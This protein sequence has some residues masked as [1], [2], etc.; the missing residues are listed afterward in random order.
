[1]PRD[2]SGNFTRPVAP[3]TSGSVVSSTDHNAEHDDFA[4]GLTASV[5]KDGQTTMTGN[6]PMGGNRITSLAN[7]SARMDAA[8]VGQVQDGSFIWGGTAGGSANARTISV[9]PAI[10]SYATGQTFRFINGAAANSGAATLAINGLTAI[11][12]VK[13]DGSALAAGDLAANAVIEV[14][15][16]GS[17]FAAIV[18]DVRAGVAN[19]FTAAQTISITT[20]AA[21]LTVRSTEGGAG[22]ASLSLDRNSSSPANNDALFDLAWTGRDNA[23]GNRTF[24]RLQALIRT[25]T[26]ASAEGEL[27]AAILLAGTLTTALAIRNG[28]VIGAATGGFQGTGTANATGFFLNGTALPVQRRVTSPN[29]AI[30][31]GATIT[32]AHSLGASPTQ[33]S[34]RVV[35][36]TAQYGWT[37]GQV[38]QLAPFASDVG[39]GFSLEWDGTNVLVHVGNQG[40]SLHNKSA[41]YG[42]ALLT[43]ANWAVQI[44]ADA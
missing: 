9:T 18:A 43:P 8:P 34:V 10:T 31:N 44:V 40:L 21:A 12:I 16:T 29:Q 37:A 25:V 23:A 30:T 42:T 27:Q 28:L 19:T 32:W 7:A 24:A 41:G 4:N 33:V 13:A 15:Y 14:V 36:L 35:N 38:V 20:A 11:N 2:G 6:L 5:A 22:A 39:T 26:A 3:Y 1:M 17:A